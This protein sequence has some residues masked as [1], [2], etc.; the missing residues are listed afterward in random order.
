MNVISQEWIDKA[1]G[2][3]ATARREQRVRT[4][5][6]FDAVCFHAQQSIEKYLKCLLCELE[7]P[8]AKTHDLEVLLDAVTVDYPL[9]EALR[10]DV[11]LLTQY[12]VQYRYPGENADRDEA[13]EALKAMKRVRKVLRLTLHLNN[14]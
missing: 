5:P 12:A 2:D 1:E 3:Y 7:K 8:Y 13:R 11:Q 10:S 14:D 6:N 9:L 4:Q